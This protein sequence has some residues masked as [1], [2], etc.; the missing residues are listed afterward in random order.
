MYLCVYVYKLLGFLMA[1]CPRYDPV[2][3][4][5]H[6][7]QDNCHEKEAVKWGLA[8]SFRGLLSSWWKADR[9]GARTV[10]ESFT[11]SLRVRSQTYDP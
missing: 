5:G 9:H 1:V 6:H 8:Y 2:V 3:T 7:D 10:A 4:M 11:S